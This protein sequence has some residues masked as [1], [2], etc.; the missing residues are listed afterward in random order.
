MVYNIYGRE[1]AAHGGLKFRL[2]IVLH[3]WIIF[4]II[5]RF[6]ITIS[7]FMNRGGGG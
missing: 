7:S 6:D 4:W 2:F 3:F 5:L 1:V